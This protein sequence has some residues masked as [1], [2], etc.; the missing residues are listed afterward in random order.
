MSDAVY[1][2]QGHK[3]F[4]LYLIYGFRIGGAERHLL[5]LCK[6]LDRS[7]FR[8]EII[9][10]HREEQMLPEFIQAG[11]PC[12]I[13]PVEGGEL[14]LRE[15]WRLSRLIKRLK[16]DIVH[17]HL[18]HAS[19]FGA[20]AAY[21][22][23]ISRI[24]R[25]RHNV[26][27]PGVKPGKKDRIWGVLLPVILDQTVAV[28]KAIAAQN[29]TPHVIYNGVD[30]NFFNPEVFDQSQQKIFSAEFGVNGSPVIGIAA[31]LTRQK[32]HV[33]LLKAFSLL[34]TDYPDAQLLIAGDG[35]ERAT[36][37]QL[38][39]ELKLTERV[40]FLGPIRKVREFLSVLDLFVHPSIFEG[41]GIAVIEAMS[42]ALP[43]VATKV[44]GL[45]ELITDGVEG[46]LVEPDNSEELSSAMGRVLGD[47]SLLRELGRQARLKAVDK[48]SIET[49][50]KKYEELYLELC[51]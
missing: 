51:G 34:L 9:Y 41:L 33:N 1:T 21:M 38:V 29:R 40:S 22:A 28:S 26:A 2:Y 44:D 49:M 7:K 36:L 48:F 46:I 13:F 39:I 37:E 20:M 10:F 50:V 16:P 31:R 24:I 12:S 42:M 17:V 6:G 14:T 5:D 18:F 25:T 11:I 8:P 19:R 30:T 47:P 32:G 4:I 3:I 15:M 27:E 35:E 23:G 43:I 45:T